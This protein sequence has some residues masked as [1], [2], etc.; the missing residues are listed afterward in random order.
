MFPRRGAGSSELQQVSGK[1]STS[2]TEFTA[3]K[4]AAVSTEGKAVSLQGCALRQLRAGAPPACD[5]SPERLE[6]LICLVCLVFFRKEENPRNLL[7]PFLGLFFFFSC[8]SVR[9]QCP[10]MSQSRALLHSPGN[11]SPSSSSYITLSH[12]V[13]GTLFP[14]VTPSP[15]GQATPGLLNQVGMRGTGPALNV[16]CRE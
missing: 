9:A 15:G 7:L 14:T 4:W 1:R 8:C 11:T 12:S 3:L 2:E 6:L 5:N 16:C 10:A 13:R